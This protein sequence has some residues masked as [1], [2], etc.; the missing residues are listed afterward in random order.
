MKTTII[1][2]QAVDQYWHEDCLKCGCCDCRLG[3]VSLGPNHFGGNR[4]G[5]NHGSSNHCGP[6]HSGGNHYHHDGNHGGETWYDLEVSDC[7]E[8]HFK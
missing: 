2:V 8:P 7:Q 3:E 4:V 1:E 6:N 5:G